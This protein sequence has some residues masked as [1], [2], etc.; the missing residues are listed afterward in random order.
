MRTG[1]YEVSADHGYRSISIHARG[2]AVLANSMTN[3]DTAFSADERKA[4][5]LNGLL[6]SGVNTIEEQ[7]ARAYA[8]YGQVDGNLERNRFLGTLRDRNEVLFYRVL[9]SH[10][11]EMLPVVYTP[12]IGEAIQRYS[13]DY[14]RPRGVFLSI[15][16][17]EDIEEALL[18]H[19]LHADEVDLL[20]VTDSEGILGIGDQG[21]GGVQ[22]AIGKLSVYTAAAGLHPRRVIPVVLDTGTDNEALLKD[23]MY[24][25]ERHPRVRGEAYDDF[26][27]RFVATS[28]R[29]FP[30][31]MIHWEDFGTANAH[32]ILTRYR[33]TACTFNDDIQGTAAVALAAVLAAVEQSGVPLD[34]HRVLVYGAGTAGIG[35]A[36]L[37][38]ETMVA[39][40]AKGTGHAA[41]YPMTSRGLLVDDMTELQDFQA[42]YAR[43]RA[44]VAEWDVADPGRIS[45]AE[46]VR[47]AQPTIWIGTS[48][49]GGA[50]T[51]SLVT[52]MAGY[53]KRPIIMPMSNPTSRAEALPADLLRWTDGAA[54]V[55]TGSPFDPVEYGGVT[56]Q[57]AQANNALIF[58][59][60][61]LGVV[62]AQANRVTDG[63]IQASATALAGLLEATELGSCLLPSMSRLREVSE[64]VAVAVVR[65][66]VDDGVAQAKLTDIDAEVRER[67]WLPE[68][69][70]V[71]ID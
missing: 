68:Y 54:L 37:L 19:G 9:S 51:E 55:A 30:Q 21:V 17:P 49:H 33:D 63:M 3:R 18:N 31:A 59:G 67:M 4:L 48:T 34:E 44:E 62:V 16:H 42:P 52:E 60:L 38:R 70:D 29:L 20:V 12:T 65:A 41:F 1:D 39:S 28:S 43:S 71:L 2:R 66:A 14:A 46:V 64:V 6:P 27:E 23:P 11:E 36:D 25:G 53:C 69:A 40:G 15:D 61:G 57:I 7:A 50:F 8:Q 45:L 10:I 35:V 24:V 47:H 22:I 56:Y 13:N 26:I 5:A 58:P 32:R